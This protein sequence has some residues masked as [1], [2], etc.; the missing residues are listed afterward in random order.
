MAAFIALF[1]LI[2]ALSLLLL[3]QWKMRDAGWMILAITVLL[4]SLF[5]AFHRTPA[6]IAVSLGEG[7][8]T[9]AATYLVRYPLYLF[10][11]LQQE[12]GAIALLGQG[13]ARKLPSREGQTLFLVLG[14]GP[15]L[16]SLCGYGSGI[17]L[18][19][20]LLVH[21][22]HDKRKAIQLG[23][24]SQIMAA[25]GSLGGGMRLA[26]DLA[27]LPVGVLSIHTALLLVPGTLG[28]GVLAL[29]LS[30]G[31]WALERYW[32]VAFCASGLL[33]FVAC[34]CCQYFTVEFAG[35]IAGVTVMAFLLIW[36]QLGRN[37]AWRAL[38]V[39]RLAAQ[40]L[41]LAVVLLPYLL[42]ASGIV[43][44]RLLPSLQ[45]FLQT[46]GVVT[47]SISLEVWSG[48]GVWLLL[49]ALIQIPL[50]SSHPLRLGHLQVIV[51]RR[52]CRGAT[53]MESFLA[54]AA[55]M[56][57][58]GMTAALG[59]AVAV[60]EKNHVWVAALVGAL[61]G[62]LT[63]TMLGGNALAVPMQKEVSVQ[64]DLPLP[65]LVAVQNASVAMASAASPSRIL[66][67]TGSAGFGEQEAWV[68]RQ[69]GWIILWSLALTTLLLVWFTSACWPGGVIVLLAL[70]LVVNA[71]ILWGVVE[72]ENKW[73]QWRFRF[74]FP[75]KTLQAIF[76]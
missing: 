48:P 1:P 72:G 31:K 43:T 26:A 67:L 11:Y 76:N 38:Y 36:G 42:L 63:S 68:F 70:L 27:R 53:T 6:Q 23:L 17:V 56:Q 46:H 50:C 30:G 41:S 3:F 64:T 73:K 2:V 7:M 28:F 9:I 47:V 71:P 55:L 60:A 45:N 12:T 10:S 29:L 40:E 20:P 37:A 24:L 32:G 21:V 52:L 15:C 16:E 61:A 62:W 35:V 54:T 58:C 5:P 19:F 4:T 14:M 25:W 22:H 57:D 13:L 59:S 44:T 8:A 75:H 51:G 69:V 34:I 65:W 66:L 39:G 74:S 33:L 49:A 18:T